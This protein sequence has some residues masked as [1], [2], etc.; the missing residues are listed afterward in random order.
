MDEQQICA[1]YC[2]I[3]DAMGWT[4]GTYKADDYKVCVA[5]KNCI[6]KKCAAANVKGQCYR[7]AD[8]YS[9]KLYSDLCTIW[10]DFTFIKLSGNR[11]NFVD[12][13]DFRFSCDYIGPS[14]AWAYR[15]G[16][17]DEIIG[18][19]LLMSRTIGGHILWPVHPNPTINTARAGGG[20][21]FDRI[22]LTLYEIRRFYLG[23]DHNSEMPISLWNVLHRNIEKSYL[24]RYSY[25]NKQGI[26]AFKAFI[27]YWK[28]QDFVMDEDYK[29][30]SF[31]MSDEHTNI[32][33]SEN[34]PVFPGNNNI[35]MSWKEITN[36]KISETNRKILCVA[37]SKYAENLIF[38]IQK[39]NER[40]INKI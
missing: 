1:T 22:D 2:Y 15:V 35:F 17:K 30:V 26:D 11:L 8:R 16:I 36:E 37:Y 9:C 24:L 5:Q 34:E 7:D 25:N 12:K 3:N 6:T 19:Y 38:A 29:V 21:L 40:I 14:R 18:E 27:D 20:S 13:D 23:E 32:P 31:A 10:N 4:S 33:V 28:L 39:R